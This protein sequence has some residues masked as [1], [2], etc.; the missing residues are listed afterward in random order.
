MMIVREKKGSLLLLCL[1]SLAGFLLWFG[2][3]SAVSLSPLTFEINVNKGEA[4]SNYI[5]VFNNE[6]GK[7]SYI[8][9][10]ED[11][12]AVGETGNVVIDRDA[13]KQVSAKQWITFEPQSF[14]VDAGQSRDIQFTL[15]VPLD[16]DPGGKYTSLLV[17]SAPTAAIGGGVGI[18][19]KVASLLLIR[20]AGD[21]TEKV[22]VQSFDA[23]AFSESGPVD[24]T[25]RLKNEGTVHLKPAGYV[26][27]KNWSGGETD[28][29][30]V[31]QERIIPGTTRATKVTWNSKW[32]FG[33]YTANFTGI[34]GAANDPL[35]A[36][37]S[38]WVIPWK[39]IGSV[40]LGLFL[41]GFIFWMMRRRLGLALKI[42]FKGQVQG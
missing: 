33:K 30:A 2:L 11:F 12:S 1:V 7:Q 21:I 19:S 14:E 28:K 26:F 42:L 20:V 22:T 31:P 4:V 41:I 34:Y 9:E 37:V 24:L 32:L 17:S 3:A 18:A 39:L 36:S 10:A 29:I 23:P 25:L 35:T 38:F 40:L 8:L 16:A 27:I 15:H 6:A 13:P 5:T